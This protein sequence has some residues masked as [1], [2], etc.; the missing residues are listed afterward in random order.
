MYMRCRAALHGPSDFPGGGYRRRVGRPQVILSRRF[1]VQPTMEISRRVALSRLS[2]MVA[3][4]V[5]PWRFALDFE[6]PDPRP[7]ITAVNVLPDE[8]IGDR[9]GVREAY[10]AAREYPELFDGLYCACECSESMK[11]RSLLSCFESM[12]PAGCYGCQEQAKLVARL[13]KQGKTLGDIRKA[14]D[15][16]WG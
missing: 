1:C 4:A 16:K 15:D 14:V 13:A 11:H 9:K 8:R 12:Q 10:A 3:V 5:V 7:G 2:R 6:H